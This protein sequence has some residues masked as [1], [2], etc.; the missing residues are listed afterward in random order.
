[1]PDGPVDPGRPRDANAFDQPEG[2]FGQKY[3]VAKEAAEGR[4]TA[5]RPSTAPASLDTPPDNGRRAT[6]DPA[7]GEVHGSGVGAGGGQP[8]EDFDGDAASGDGYPV[9]G[10][11][12]NDRRPGDLGPPHLGE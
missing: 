5:D 12:G 8:G 3:D 7:T 2:F 4:R 10:G 9:T 1:M 6:I 11:E